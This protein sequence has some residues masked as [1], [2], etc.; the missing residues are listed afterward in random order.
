MHS[1]LQFGSLVRDERLRGGD[2]SPSVGERYRWLLR[3]RANIH[4]VS[5]EGRLFHAIGARQVSPLYSCLR[6]DDPLF[7]PPKVRPVLGGTGEEVRF[8][9]PTIDE[10]LDS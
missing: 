7:G 3:V 9:R 10:L 8:E 2:S 1:G 4:V 6:L 5:S